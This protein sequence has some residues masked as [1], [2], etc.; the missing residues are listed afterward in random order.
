[1]TKSGPARTILCGTILILSM[2]T[3]LQATEWFVDAQAG[4]DFYNGQSPT[5]GPAGTGPK[6][7][8]Q[9]AI[10]A[11]ANADTVTAA[12]GLYTGWGNCDL[13]L[14][15]KALVVRSS[16]GPDATVI[17]PGGAPDWPHRAFTLL[18]T[19]T[20]GT[21]IEGFTLQGGFSGPSWGG[22]L[23]CED[24]NV[25]V[26]NCRFT[27]NKSDGKG[28]AVYCGQGQ[29]RLVE[30]SFQANTSPE[31]GALYAS[32]A[33]VELIACE[34]SANEATG[35]T[36]EGLGGAAAF[37]TACTAYVE[38][39]TFQANHAGRFGGALHTSD[40]LLS[41]HNSLILGNRAGS[42]GGGLYAE[43]ATVTINLCTLSGNAAAWFGGGLHTHG[44]TQL[45]LTNTICWD[46]LVGP[47][48]EGPQL[49]LGAYVDLTATYNCIQ[50]G[51]D[52]V[53][54]DNAAAAGWDATN[55]DVWPGFGAPGAWLPEP[56]PA[57]GDATWLPGDYH[58]LSTQG[59]WQPDHDP[60]QN[61]GQWVADMEDSALIDTGDPLTPWQA[62]CWP[63]GA[64]VNL[65][66]YGGTS[67]ASLSCS[68]VGEPA[69][70]DVDGI[71]N[72]ADFAR[73]TDRW[74][75]TGQPTPADLN[76]DGIVDP[77]DLVILLS[78][79]LEVGPAT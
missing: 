62:E 26:R 9:A 56:F 4:S 21:R 74:F 2:T 36:G 48:G 30:C 58:L 64:I 18:G 66:A 61:Q 20:A 27:G 49:A 10:E 1:M 13:I 68:M 52:A 53:R 40:S 47:D 38:T 65:G 31:G 75:T 15:D 16:A 60:T 57:A 5:P 3:A 70:L 24:T 45:L 28:G 25:E 71:V 42:Y 39:T 7:T 43:N 69:D 59:R 78:R 11:A 79:W 12:P 72:L 73:L 50:G 19:L 8:L 14:F 41:I 34:F 17:D 32:G 37:D 67:Q 6:Q 22:S 76:H 23:T 51:R 77:A 44:Q 54:W 29:L 35:N 46:N 63:N 55:I 33:V